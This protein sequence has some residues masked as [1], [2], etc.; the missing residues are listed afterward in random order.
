MTK[1][2][3]IFFRLLLNLYWILLNKKK[4]TIQKTDTNIKAILAD[5]KLNVA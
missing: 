1:M 5:F 4:S 3:T 2:A